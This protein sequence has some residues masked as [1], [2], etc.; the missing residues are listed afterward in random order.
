MLDQKISVYV[1]FARFPFRRLFQ[2]AFPPAVW[3]V[4]VS[5]EPQ[6]DSCTL[7]V[8]SL[9][10][11]KWYLSV[12][13]LKFVLWVWMFSMFKSHY[14]VNYVCVSYFHFSIGTLV[15]CLFTCQG[16]SPLSV[17]YVWWTSSP[18]LLLV[19]SLYDL[20]FVMQSFYCVVILLMT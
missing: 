6:T 13:F 8:G 11:K 15:L 2:F 1:D 10:G 9:I 17:V 18:S 14:L 3:R 16:P 19:C 4:F 20:L 12:G 7:I 5:P